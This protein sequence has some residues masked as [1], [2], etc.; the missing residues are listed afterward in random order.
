MLIL[1]AGLSGAMGIRLADEAL[2]RNHNV[3][4]LGRSKSKI[5]DGVAERLERFVEVST[6]YDVPALENACVGVDAVICAYA[7]EPTLL[8]EAQL[9]LLCA[10]ERA[11]IKKIVADSWNSD[12]RNIRVG[13]M[14]SYDPYLCLRAQLRLAAS[15]LR[16]IFLLTGVFAESWFGSKD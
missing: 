6:W 8:L 5:S 1:I 2:K 3:R 15:N 10:A 14:E 13:D 4:V 11:G 7:L 12:Y 9:F 16:P